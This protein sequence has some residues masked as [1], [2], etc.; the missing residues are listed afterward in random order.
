MMA[1]DEFD[2]WGAERTNKGVRQSER[3]HHDIPELNAS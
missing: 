2:A 3:T 1:P